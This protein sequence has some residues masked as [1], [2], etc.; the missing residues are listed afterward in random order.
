MIRGLTI[1]AMLVAVST[2]LACYAPYNPTCP[3]RSGTDG[4]P[5]ASGNVATC[6]NNGDTKTL[7]QVTASGANSL[8][9]SSGNCT[10][11]CTYIDSNGVKVGCGTLSV[12]WNGSQ[13]DSSTCPQS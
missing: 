10:Y 12:P 3:N 2:A 1:A 11:T 8:K 5:D 7:N 13:P 4:C 9:P 6:A